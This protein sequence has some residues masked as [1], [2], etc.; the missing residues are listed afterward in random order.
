MLV[1]AWEAMYDAIPRI[2]AEEMLDAY[3]VGVLSTPAPDEDAAS[4]RQ[5]IV[6]EWRQMVIG[7][8][9]KVI[10]VTVGK[11]REMLINA[12]DEQIRD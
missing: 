8:S 4:K 12:F 2:H 3:M 5:K 11:L 1:I 10:E 6:D 9:K 7:T